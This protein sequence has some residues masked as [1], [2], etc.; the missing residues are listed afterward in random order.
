MYEYP[1]PPP[2]A[3]EPPL[4]VRGRVVV[5]KVPLA[6]SWVA[7]N[8]QFFPITNVSVSGSRRAGCVRI[9]ADRTDGTTSQRDLNVH[10]GMF[11]R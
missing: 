6:S 7:W 10:T 1:I 4:N 2:E 3:T 5:C 8:E 11:S 9:T